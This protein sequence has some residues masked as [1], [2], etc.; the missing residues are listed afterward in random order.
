MGKFPPASCPL[1]FPDAHA[2][3]SAL[4]VAGFCCLFPSLPGNLPF[5]FWLLQGLEKEQGE[6]DLK[7]Q[8]AQ[9]LQEVTYLATVGCGV[10]GSQALLLSAHL[11]GTSSL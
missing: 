4:L 10:G 2:S 5:G 11:C 8:L 6:E 3:W 9:A 1:L 7:Q